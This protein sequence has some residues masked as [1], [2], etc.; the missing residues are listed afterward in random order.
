M[1]ASISAVWGYLK[2][3]DALQA[4]SEAKEA[5]QKQQKAEEQ[6]QQVTDQLNKAN[7]AVEETVHSLIQAQEQEIQTIN[8]TEKAKAQKQEAEKKA[9]KAQQALEQ[10]KIERI[11]LEQEVKT[12]EKRTQEA[13][14]EVKQAQEL[15]K[16]A[17]QELDNAKQAKTKAE[18]ALKQTQDALAKTNKA[19]GAVRDLT[20]LAGKLR[21]EGKVE[22]SDEALR[23]AGLSTLIDNEELKQAWL[24]AATAESYKFLGNEGWQKAQKT[25]NQ[26]NLDSLDNNKSQ[27]NQGILNQARAFVYFQVGQLNDDRQAYT[28]AYEALKISN[29][30]PYNLNIETDILTEQDVENIHYR[31]IKSR[32]IDINSS[33]EIAISFRKHLYAGLW[34][35][36]E[37]DRLKEADFKTTEIMLYIAGRKEERYFTVESLENFSCSALREIDTLWYNY[38]KHPQHF[39]FRVQKEIWQE[40]GS[41]GVDWEK[42]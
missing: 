21:K 35:L 30:N 15:V 42:F 36:L 23:K 33:D 14:R 2:F 26:I 24:L 39:G 27:L 41:P 20:V 32:N 34:D 22:A 40:V 5:I 12:L 37:K 7:K 16:K 19:L 9:E 28:K 17:S 8:Q 11:S 38:P 3:Q 13:E 4:Q 18:N 31:L 1:G 10:A 29:F 25:L 6:F